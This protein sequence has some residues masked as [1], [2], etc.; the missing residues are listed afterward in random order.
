MKSNYPQEY[1]HTYFNNDFFFIKYIIGSKFN[2]S[3]NKF[4]PENLESAANAISN[5]NFF[6]NDNRFQYVSVEIKDN[7]I[8]VNLEKWGRSAVFYFKH[9][10]AV[11]I[12]SH[13][14]L[15]YLAN[16][17]YPF[18]IN[19]NL[20]IDLFNRGYLNA[21]QT[22]FTDIYK[23]KPDHKLIVHQNGGIETQ[24]QMTLSQK[25]GI[26]TMS[27]EWLHHTIHLLRKAIVKLI[28]NGASHL[29][30]SGG[31][32]SR[33]ILA[34]IPK[35][36]RSK[37]S[38]YNKS[39]PL[40][41]AT[42]DN[43]HLLAEKIS[44]QY[45]FKFNPILEPK[46]YIEFLNPEFTNEKVISGLYGGEFLG[47][48]LNWF[49]PDEIQKSF[50]VT[51]PDAYRNLFLAS[52]NSFRTLFHRKTTSSWASPYTNLYSTFTPFLDTD[53]L[54]HF[55]KVDPA[56]AANYKVYDAIWKMS[57]FSD[58]AK[59]GFESGINFYFD[60]PKTTNGSN[61]K[62]FSNYKKNTLDTEVENNIAFLTQGIFNSDFKSIRF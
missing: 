11:Y 13:I 14:E 12:S 47:G 16:K 8:H 26:E 53:F 7:K 25:W 39:N 33:L 4:S 55:V 9:N 10:D 48:T 51:D 19:K 2:F 23:L 60:Y 27:T 38:T 17:K 24:D 20:K 35:S 61:P 52:I 6:I 5:E 50:S 59:I 62:V 30:L 49:L 32:D 3:T 42:Q 1:T 22:L 36:M 57:E 40:L 43:D 18:D 21:D 15:I 34:L 37:V 45:G 58:F 41:G 56:Q 54:D 31:C 44:E 29:A 28:E 46:N